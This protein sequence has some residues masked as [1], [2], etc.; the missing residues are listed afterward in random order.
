[1]HRH[2]LDKGRVHLVQCETHR[3]VVDFFDFGDVLVH[4]HVGE[5]RELTGIGFSERVVLVQHALEGKDYVVGVEFA[6]GLEVVGGVKF[7]P[8]AQMKGVGP[9]VVADVPA[10]RQA[11]LGEGA[12]ALELRETVEYGFSGGVEI[13]AGGVLARVEAGWAAFGAIHQVAGSE[14]HG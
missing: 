4:S 7:N 11:G 3:H 2:V 1:M 6:A 12:A 14:A 5:I 13:G 10:G 8:G 9:A